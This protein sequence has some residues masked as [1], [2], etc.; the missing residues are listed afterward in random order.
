MSELG[1]ST[2]RIGCQIGAALLLLAFL[3][4]ALASAGAPATTALAQGAATNTPRPSLA[5]L[6]TQAAIAKS[7]T[8]PPL[9]SVRFNDSVSW[10]REG[11]AYSLFVRSFRDSDGDGIGD[12]QGVIAQ[13]DYLQGLGINTI[14]LLP[15]FKAGSYHGYDTTDYYNVNP[16]YGSNADLIALF[17]A[18]H[19]R[20][21]H[22]L[23]D[24]VFNHTSDQHPYFRS[25]FRNPA[26]EYAEYYRWFDAEQSTYDSF[27][28]IRSLPRLNLE[29]VKV[30]KFAFSV[31][32]Y[33]L[34]PNGD[35]NTNDGADG[36]RADVATGLPVDFWRQ[37]RVVINQVNPRAVLLG[38]LWTEGPKIAEYLQG[39]AFNAAFDF[40]TYMALTGHHDRNGDGLLSGVGDQ[41]LLG[42]N[43]RAMDVLKSAQSMMVRFSHNHDTNRILSDVQGDLLRARAAAVWLLTTPGVP[44]LYYGEEIGMAG[45]KGNGPAYDEYRREPLDWYGTEDGPGMTRWFKPADRKNAPNDGISVEEQ[46]GAADSMLALYQTLGNLR[47]QSPALRYGRGQIER[48]GPLYLLRR[49]EGDQ[50]F[51]VAINFSG[52][53]QTLGNISGLLSIDGQNYKPESLAV[54]LAQAAGNLTATVGESITLQPGGFVVLKAGK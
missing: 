43:M 1:P 50:F 46:N 47:M 14:W 39:D 10:F 27:A 5:E 19:A 8:P 36:Y 4:S 42:L 3:L 21:M 7:A 54:V 33:W 23:L 37:L 52:Q 53:A 24:Y 32:T 26:S 22:I 41:G 2:K 25:A 11:I 6:A 17:E 16:D 30:R 49:F 48:G 12:L 51:L 34:D 38:E 35:G 15:V 31:A 28:G 20:G 45:V 44:I 9:P 40:P 13:L 29:S 18:A